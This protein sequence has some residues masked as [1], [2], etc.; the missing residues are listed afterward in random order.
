MADGKVEY[1]VG[2]DTSSYDKDLEQLKKTAESAGN[3]AAAA[4]DK[5]ADKAEK[6][7]KDSAGAA[8]K[9]TKQASENSAASAE[10]GSQIITKAYKT[11]IATMEKAKEVTGSWVDDIDSMIY[12]LREQISAGKDT[13]GTMQGLLDTLND[14][15]NVMRVSNDTLGTLNEQLV[16]AQGEY[17]AAT[18]NVDKFGLKSA[19]A[20]EEINNTTES[21][22]K[23]AEEA[24]PYYAQKLNMTTDEYEDAINRRVEVTQNAFE[25]IEEAEA[26]SLDA[27][28]DNLQSNQVLVEEWTQNLG[29]LTERGLDNGLLRVLEEAGPEAAGTVRNLVNASDEELKALNNVF[30]AGSE[31]AV[32]TL[33]ETMNLPDTTNAG[34]DAVDNAAEGMEENDA[35]IETAEAT[36]TDTKEAMVNAVRLANFDEVGKQIVSGMTA[37][38]TSKSGELYSRV[39]KIVSNAISKAKAAAAVASPSKKTTEIFEYVGEG[40]IVGLEHKRKKLLDTAED[41]TATTIAELTPNITNI[42]NAVSTSYNTSTTLNNIAAAEQTARMT[43]AGNAPVYLYLDGNLCGSTL[44][45]YMSYSLEQLRVQESRGG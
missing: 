40:M 22:Q 21:L 13:D 30:E 16:T 33:L 37:G 9:A 35:L 8:E 7:V 20:A 6:S 43:A 31:E 5:S 29:I 10:K 1:T 34:A 45:P 36:V 25:K 11:A 2:A 19:E 27:M 39:S 3:S 12:I 18:E 15:D 14:C 32:Q 28:I 23:Q 41:I 4:V 17:D 26:V 24:L 44:A 42:S 38:M